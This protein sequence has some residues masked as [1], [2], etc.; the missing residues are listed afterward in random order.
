M[1]VVSRS[2]RYY[3]RHHLGLALSVAIAC[4]VLVSGLIV[5]GI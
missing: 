5:L 2:L 1:S 3:W 4:A